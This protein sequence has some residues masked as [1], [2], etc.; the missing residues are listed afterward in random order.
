L[1]GCRQ[2]PA[3]K[4]DPRRT[5]KNFRHQSAGRAG[6]KKTFGT[7]A[8]AAPEQKKLLAPKR[9]PRRSKKNFWR[10]SAGRAGAKKTF[11]TKARAAPD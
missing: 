5:E 11:G 4:R 3:P 7:N 9:G 6:L 1:A 10:Q 8:R 2:F